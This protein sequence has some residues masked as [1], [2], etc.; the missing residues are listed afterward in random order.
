TSLMHPGYNALAALIYHY[1]INTTPDN[2]EELA[3]KVSDLSD[4]HPDMAEEDKRV[5]QHILETQARLEMSSK[6]DEED[7]VPL[8]GSYYAA[9]SQYCSMDNEKEGKK[10]LR[11]A[12]KLFEEEFAPDPEDENWDDGSYDGDDLDMGSIKEILGTE[13]Y[14][15]IMNIFNG[16]KPI[17]QE[18]LDADFN[19]LMN[20]R[21]PDAKGF[22]YAK[23]AKGGKAAGDGESEQERQERIERRMKEL[24]EEDRA[25]L[26]KAKHDDGYDDSW[27]DDM[28]DKELEA[29]M[30]EPLEDPLDR[31]LDG[32]NKP[33]DYMEDDET[34]IV[35]SLF[36]E[37]FP[38]PSRRKPRENGKSRS[39]DEGPFDPDTDDTDPG[40]L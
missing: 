38:S 14:N 12:K 7:L 18:I 11:K 28:T 20:M 30:N 17:P 9:Y 4:S 16:D 22:G 33:A 21:G 5:L 40:E 32:D 10:H 29:L 15:Q 13:L 37:M 8:L 34:D 35:R 25:F 2:L 31:F 39:Q 26:E 3:D 19:D 1:L 6:T 24:E 27:M 36:K 23:G